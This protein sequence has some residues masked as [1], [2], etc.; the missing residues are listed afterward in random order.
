[1]KTQIQ[2]YFLISSSGWSL[3]LEGDDQDSELTSSHCWLGCN[4][5]TAGQTEDKHL[6]P[7]QILYCVWTLACQ[8]L[9]VASAVWSPWIPTW[10]SCTAKNWGWQLSVGCRLKQILSFPETGMRGK[11]VKEAECWGRYFGSLSQSLLH[12]SFLLFIF[13]IFRTLLRERALWAMV[14]P[15]TIFFLLVHQQEAR[16][17][18]SKQ[19]ASFQVESVVSILQNT[20]FAIF[21]NGVDLHLHLHL[22]LTYPVFRLICC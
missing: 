22:H 10:F 20:E 8:C 4:I 19:W 6:M 1:M 7:R 18:N 3:L 2:T 16:K 14:N 5:N 13:F 9:W 15:W 12:R 21:S 17:L 11:V